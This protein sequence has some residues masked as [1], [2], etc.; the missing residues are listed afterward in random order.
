MH[1]GACPIFQAIGRTDDAEI[2]RNE[3]RLGDLIE[4]LGF[5]SLWG[6]EHH[7]TDY[8]MCPDVFQ[9][10]AYFAGRTRKVQLG[11]MVVVLPWNDPMRVAEKVSML[12][13]QSNG[14]VILGIGRG[15]GRVEFEGFGVDQNESRPRFI[16]SAEMVLEGLERGWCEY[17]GKYIKQVKREIRPR[18]MKGF[19]GRSYAAAMSPESQPIMARLGVGLLVIPM[20]PWEQHAAEIAAYAA[21]F[22]EYQK[23]PAPA[24]WITAWTFCDDNADRAEE[25][26][27]KYIGGYW[28][29]VIEHYELVGDHLGKTKG[30]E[31]YKAMQEAAS[32]AGGVDAMAEMFVNLH[33]WGTPEQCYEKIVN[34]CQK[35]G[36]DAFTGVF[37]Y[38]GMPYEDAERSMT[39]FAK[40]VIPELHAVGTQAKAA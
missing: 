37:S 8:T 7:F 25:K 17:D 16:E 21:A 3:L 26:A 10:L 12:E 6:V 30:Y 35:T 36:G 39:L 13:H 9:H 18:P 5:D 19:H 4:P 24:P 33:V 27:R 15:L 1:V 20:K 22:R 14:R 32:T 23:A 38:A 34:T 40:K 11:T 28:R 2:Y 29:S 31:S